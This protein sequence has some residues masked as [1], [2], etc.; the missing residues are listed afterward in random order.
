MIFV[1]N[2]N[3]YHNLQGRR[4]NYRKLRE[5]VRGGRPLTGAR[6]YMGVPDPVSPGKMD[7]IRHLK[8][9]GYRVLTK[10]L[11]GGRGN[12]HQKGVDVL[13]AVDM[14]Q[15]AFED[16]YD[17]AVLLSGDADFA[18][19]IDRVQSLGKEVEVWSFECSLAS[20]LCD[21]VGRERVEM[22]DSIVRQTYRARRLRSG[23]RHY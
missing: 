4:I 17:V 3:I 19:A 11:G 5:A 13:L 6:V 20:A 14:L 8:L 15:L 22:L 18:P 1:D 21:C 16:R 2:E 9:C 12:P 10:K 7:F 23:W